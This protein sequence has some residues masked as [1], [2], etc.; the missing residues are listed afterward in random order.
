MIVTTGRADYG[1]LHP[2][3]TKIIHSHKLALKLVVTGSHLSKQHGDT[4]SQVSADGLT[5]DHI[6]AMSCETDS[7]HAICGSIA[8]GLNGFSSLYEMERPDLVVVLGDRYELLSVCIAALMHKIPIAHIHGG[9]ATFGI[10]DEAVRHSVTKMSTLHFPSIDCYKDRIIQLGESPENVFVVG[11]LGIDNIKSMQ[12]LDCEELS[13]TF[14]I[15]FSQKVALVTYHPVT[16]DAYESSSLQIRTLLDA[17]IESNVV[18]L[19]TMPNADPGNKPIFDVIKDYELRYPSE[20]KFRKNLGQV[21]YLSAMKYA[22][23]MVGNSSSGII[24]SASFKLPVIN[25]G[26]RQK[27][28]YKPDNIIDVECAGLEIKDAIEKALSAEFNDS[29]VDLCNPYGDGGTAEKII[30]ILESLDFR[31]LQGWIKKQFYDLSND[32]IPG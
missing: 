30:N 10:V 17:L 2:L 21:G 26:D 5:V 32:K 24:E 23:L 8:E 15:D 6:V 27:G 16:L 13:Q 14:E 20:I 22:S 25:V 12:L 31:E 11:A 19:I 29:L 28:R 1:L 9:E 18:S 3:M 4:L 7:E